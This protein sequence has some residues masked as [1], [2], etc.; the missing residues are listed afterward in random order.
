[1]LDDISSRLSHKYP[2]YKSDNSKV[3]SYMEES[4]CGTTYSSTMKVFSWKRD[5]RGAWRAM[6]NSHSGNDKWEELPKENNKCL[7]NTKWNGRVYTFE[8]SVT[9][10]KL[11]MLVLKRQQIMWISSFR[12]NIQGLVVCWIKYKTL[13][14][15]FALHLQT[16]VRM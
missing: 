3:Y 14:L 4:T 9:N 15:I 5:G 12:R 10:I 7:M 2:F 6:K 16:F 8:N 13:M 11:N 1:M